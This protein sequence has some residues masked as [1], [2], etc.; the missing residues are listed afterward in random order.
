MTETEIPI[1]GLV[2][3]TGPT[4]SGAGVWILR[5]PITFIEARTQPELELAC[6]AIEKACRSCHVISLI[7]YEVGSWFEPRLKRVQESQTWAPF[8]AWLVEEA[9]WLPNNAFDDWLTERL[10]RNRAH[11][12][13]SGVGGMRPEMSEPEYLKAA[14]SAKALL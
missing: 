5:E 10:E 8:Q 11:D 9:N 6:T 12:G 3:G 4:G 2:D 13:P 1:F 7:D 14:Q